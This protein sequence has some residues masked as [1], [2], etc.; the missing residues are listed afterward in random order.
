MP[1]SR[2]PTS[3]HHIG[4]HNST[5]ALTA[6]LDLHATYAKSEVADPSVRA[7]CLTQ[8][9][10]S[11]E[12]VDRLSAHWS[13][14]CFDETISNCEQDTKLLSLVQGR[15]TI[16]MD[17]SMQEVRNRGKFDGKLL[18]VVD[19][20]NAPVTA[21]NFVDLVDKKFYDGMDIQRADGFIVQT[22]DPGGEVSLEYGFSK[23]V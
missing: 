8:C 9:C 7:C 1:L 3:L 18:M 6:H 5:R 10:S 12:M 21:G 16:G 14:D 15:A 11:T 17:V 13:R 2:V 19:G 22:G 23:S 4:L 20:Y